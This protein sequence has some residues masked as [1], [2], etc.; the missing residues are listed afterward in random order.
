MNLILYTVLILVSLG[1]IAAMILFLTARKFKVFEDPHIELVTETLP[2]TNCGG[3]G[4]AGCRSLAEAIVKSED[5]TGLFCPVGGNDVMKKVADL[6]GRKA[7]AK[8]PL[9][10]VVRCSGSPN[11]RP[12]TNEYQGAVSC[13]LIHA[14]YIGDT[15]CPYGCLG[16]GDCVRACNFDALHMD[17][18]TQ[19]PV[20]D[21]ARCTACGACVK[22]C[23]RNIIELR[24]KSRHDRKI[25]VSCINKEKGGIAKKYCQVACIGCG[26]CFKVCQFDAITIADNLA[27]IDAKQCKMCRKCAPV[28]PTGAILEP[29]F[30]IRKTNEESADMQ[31]AS[32]VLTS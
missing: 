12:R 7:Q 21:D 18:E 6:L 4:F 16:C 32:S 9:V 27:Y 13:A 1:G 28:C 29:N 15:D 25:F 20:V 30:P 3:C 26:K 22:A 2:G 5:S 24:L 17:P 19:L 14:M 31:A 23:P 8:A 11:V 10:A